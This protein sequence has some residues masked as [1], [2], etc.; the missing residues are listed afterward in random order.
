L[1][2][3]NTWTY[4]TKTIVGDTSGTWLYTNGRGIGIRWDMGVGT[5][6]S[7]AATNAWGVSSAIGV[8]GT[9]K[10]TQTTGATFTITGVQL[11]KGSTATSFDYRP[12]TTELALCQRYFVKTNADNTARCG[13][14]WGSMYGSGIGHITG[15]LPVAMRVA[16]TVVRGGTSDTFYVSNVSASSAGTFQ[17]F[18]SSTLVIDTEISGMSTGGIGYP[19]QYNGQLSLSSEL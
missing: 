14:M 10:L 19:I 8:T 17:N 2:T 15:S 4:I 7:T 3:A 16:P 6:N 13:G 5:T 1:P 9:T 11:E 18:T 12:F